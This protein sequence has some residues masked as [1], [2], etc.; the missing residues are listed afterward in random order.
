VSGHLLTAREVAEQLG[1]STGAL[2]RWTRAGRVPALKLPSGA[3]RYRPEQVEAWLA[4]CEMGATAQGVSA[5]RASRARPEGYAVARLDFP[6]SAARLQDAAE[7][8]H[9][10]ED[11]AR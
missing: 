5:A 1:V 9:K 11:H 6:L 3:V 4:G 2:L 7:H 8:Q 10:E